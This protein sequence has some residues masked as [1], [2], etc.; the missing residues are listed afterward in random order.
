MALVYNAAMSKNSI[1]IAL[2]SLLVGIAI[3]WGA[4]QA[5]VNSAQQAAFSSAGSSELGASAASSAAPVDGGQES[6]SG[7]APSAE[8]ASSQ[9]AS[10]QVASSQETSSQPGSSAS[11]QSGDT[12]ERAE[13]SQPSGNADQASPASSSLD[14]AVRSSSEVEESQAGQPGA[15]N[16]SVSEDGTYTSKE[17][18]AAYIHEFG[19]L[20][21]NYISKSK[22][23]KAGWVSSEG[24]LDKVLPGMSIGGSVFY[25]DEGVLPDA[26]GRNWTECD[27]NYEGGY[28]G[29]ERIVF[30]DDGLV[31]YTGD[32][33]KTFEQ[34]Y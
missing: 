4:S 25:N 2:V 32:H 9:A 28:R 21:S 20:P 18:V 22:A 10:S 1:I 26:P 14:E 5:L 19:H 8:P 7:Q 29:A 6:S 34:L 27:I 24:N 33:Y 31:F 12:S 11:A 13:S 23:K 3:G 15:S 16:V 17:E 30:S